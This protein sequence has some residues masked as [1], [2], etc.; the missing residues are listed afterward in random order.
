MLSYFP[1]IFWQGGNSRTR[2]CVVDTLKSKFLHIRCD[3]MILTPLKYLC[4]I[5]LWCERSRFK[6]QNTCLL[7]QCAWQLCL[8]AVA[9][10]FMTPMHVKISIFC[11]KWN[12]AILKFVLVAY[13]STQDKTTP[14]L[15]S[16]LLS[17]HACA[18]RLQVATTNS[19]VNSFTRHFLLL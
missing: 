16:S 7:C 8:V 12:V 14:F 10:S 19:F 4:Y 1:I 18:M 13:Q 2:A 9:W 3:V 5:L 6:Y 17:Q 15:G 11:G